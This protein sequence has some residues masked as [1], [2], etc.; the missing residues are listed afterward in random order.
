MKVSCSGDAILSPNRALIECFVGGRRRSR[1]KMSSEDE[2]SEDVQIYR[3]IHP[4]YL[5]PVFKTLSK[6]RLAHKFEDET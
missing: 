5:V 1:V 4:T 6:T 3:F 2:E